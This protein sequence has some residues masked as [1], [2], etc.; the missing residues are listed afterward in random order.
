M[1]IEEMEALLKKKIVTAYLL[2]MSVIEIT[3][4]MQKYKI[5][6]VHSALRNAGHIR[7]VIYNEFR[8]SYDVH[9]KLA[10]AL[11]RRGCPLQSW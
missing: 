8:T 4:A 10:A 11:D 5:N 9:K 2:G 7:A 6:H 3:R 1:Q